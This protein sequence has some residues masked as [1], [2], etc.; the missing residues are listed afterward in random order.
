MYYVTD[1]HSLIWYLA[2]DEKLGKKAFSIFDKADRGEAIIIVPTIVL[3]EMIYICEK[4]RAGL[5]IKDVIH[6]IKNSLNYIPY[7]L[8]IETLEKLITIKNIPEMHDRIITAIALL[9]GSILITKDKE[10]I[11]SKIV[12]TIW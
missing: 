5:E 4:K 6:K 11:K 8:D 1:T 3:S 10:I 2:E 7:N 9:T 12:E